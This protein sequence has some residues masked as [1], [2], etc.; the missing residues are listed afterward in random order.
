MKPRFSTVAFSLVFS[1]AYLVA[2]SFDGALFRY[3]PLTGQF[4]WGHVSL[5]DAG[6][7]MAWYGLL[8]TAAVAALPA[9]L[10]LPQATLAARLRN[11][12]WVL[13]V[14]ALL[15]SAW[16]MRVLLLR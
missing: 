3:Y 13:P 11:L 4:T 16:L 8:A 5:T 9:A 6:P 12:L 1:L 15:G 7:A 2:L 10:L 14:V